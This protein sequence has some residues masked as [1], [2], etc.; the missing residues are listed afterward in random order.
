MERHSGDVKSWAPIF[1]S[2]Y[3]L[4]FFTTFC[5]R[6]GQRCLRSYLSILTLHPHPGLGCLGHFQYEGKTL[7]N[8]VDFDKTLR[9]CTV[10]PVCEYLAEQG[11][12]GR[13]RQQKAQTSY[14]AAEL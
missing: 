1:L 12:V 4:L 7:G 2:V 11:L 13:I 10:I 9:M 5:Y 3:P 14:T 8:Q 6:C